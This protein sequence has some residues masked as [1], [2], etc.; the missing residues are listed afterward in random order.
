MGGASSTGYPTAIEVMHQTWLTGQHMDDETY[1]N[2]T[3]TDWSDYGNVADDI[4]AARSDAGGSPWEN[5]VAYNPD[6]QLDMA[7]QK[8][9]EFYYE[10]AGIAAQTDVETAI[11]AVAEKLDEHYVDATETIDAVVDEAEARSILDSQ[12]AVSRFA[13]GMFDLNAVMTSQFATGIALIEAERA[14]GITDLEKR[15]YLEA[16]QTRNANL[17]PLVSAILQKAADKARGYQ[18]A[19]LL[20]GEISK[21]HIVAK[22]EEH[23]MNL[24]AEVKDATWDLDLWNYAVK[25]LAAPA[26]TAV[27][28]GPEPW[29]KALGALST[30][31]SMGLG[32]GGMFF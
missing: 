27:Q 3:G 6:S 20:Q 24:Q 12:R 21:Q 25:M 32:I 30:I 2:W 5:V 18:A 14:Q 26:G 10:V 29:E 1:T 31:V 7:Q 16:Q 13:A 17:V 28:P 4:V 11:D 23:T 19:A 22:N 8:L 15:L 9:D